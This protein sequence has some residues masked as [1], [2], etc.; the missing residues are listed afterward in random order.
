MTKSSQRSPTGISINASPDNNEFNS[1]FN[2]PSL[3][4]PSDFYSLSSREMYSPFSLAGVS[5]AIRLINFV[6]IISN[7][8]RFA[9]ARI[10][11][12]IWM[13]SRDLFKKPGP[14]CSMDERQVN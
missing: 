1:F 5:T 9:H 14:L 6:S 8:P 10:Y 4:W 7:A 2:S 3:K 13:A 11:Q 12:I